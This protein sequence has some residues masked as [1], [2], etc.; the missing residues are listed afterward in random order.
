MKSCTV[1][2]P[3]AGPTNF[4]LLNAEVILLLNMIKRKIMRI[5]ISKNVKIMNKD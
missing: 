2:L 3:L 1:F 5:K 4:R